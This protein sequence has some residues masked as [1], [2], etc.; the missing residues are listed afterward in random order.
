MMYLSLNCTPRS[1]SFKSRSTT[2]TLRSCSPPRMIV[3]L[4]N[5]L[6][7]QR[8]S[9]SSWTVGE[10]MRK[11]ELR[12]SILTS[13]CTTPS[14]LLPPP[15][16]S[17]VIVWPR[18]TFCTRRTM[19]LSKASN[20]EAPAPEKLVPTVVTSSSALIDKIDCAWAVSKAVVIASISDC[21]PSFT[22]PTSKGDPKR[23]RNFTQNLVELVLKNQIQ[24]SLVSNASP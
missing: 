4:S 6:R 14:A 22:F 5:P 10:I 8:A 16:F 9:I 21:S 18:T 24:Y 17:D 7:I 11:S 12:L 23:S 13:L 19:T 3:C 2:L 20:A 1:L 15:S